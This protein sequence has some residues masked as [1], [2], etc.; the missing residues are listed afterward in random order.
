LKS[1]F[2]AKVDFP[3]PDPPQIQTTFFFTK[4]IAEGLVSAIISSI[5]L[6]F[7]TAQLG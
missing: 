2:K 7:L 1:L 3:A 5:C 6:L 4:D